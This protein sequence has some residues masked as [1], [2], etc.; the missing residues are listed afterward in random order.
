MNLFRRKQNEPVERKEYGAWC[1]LITL[2]SRSELEQLVLI[3]Q[4]WTQV[5][6]NLMSGRFHMEH[7]LLIIKARR[8]E[9]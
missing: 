6:G 7:Y 5:N 2:L 9:E 1:E 4:G 8:N 3:E